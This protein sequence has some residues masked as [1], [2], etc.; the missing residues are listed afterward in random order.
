MEKRINQGYGQV[1]PK[2]SYKDGQSTN[3]RINNI[4]SSIPSVQLGLIEMN[5]SPKQEIRE[6][7]KEIF[8]K[9]SFPWN[10]HKR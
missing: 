3:C 6:L 8:S 1:Q 9:F 10:I 5:F 4:I 2:N 7:E